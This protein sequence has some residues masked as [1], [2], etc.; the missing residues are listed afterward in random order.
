MLRPERVGGRSPP[1]RGL[2]I[3]ESAP[4]LP[5]AAPWIYTEVTLWA[6]SVFTPCAGSVNRT[7]EVR[8][9]IVEA[10]ATGQ[11]ATETI[12]YINQYIQGGSNMTG[13]IC[14]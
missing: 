4:R 12:V 2:R 10:H 1:S 8:L 14:V 9:L 7:A 6:I 13:T 11:G 5:H 3:C